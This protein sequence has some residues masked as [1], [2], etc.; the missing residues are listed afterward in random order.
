MIA[1]A[2]LKSHY[3]LLLCSVECWHEGLEKLSDIR[4]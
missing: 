2:T 4:H 3:F 1:D